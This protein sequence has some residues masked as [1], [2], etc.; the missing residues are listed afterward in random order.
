[1]RAEFAERLAAYQKTALTAFREVEDALVA[2]SSTRR[3][4]A[5]LEEQ[6]EA[7]RASLRLATD[8]YL[9]GLSDYLPVLTSQT[10]LFEAQS[11]LLSARRQLIADRIGLAR[12]LGGTWMDSELSSR[13]T[14]S[15][16]ED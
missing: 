16:N 11:R 15:R 3:Q 4:I 7:S 6:V 10:L 5:M 14:Q 9:Q 1:S 8:R 13:L 2:N 12:A